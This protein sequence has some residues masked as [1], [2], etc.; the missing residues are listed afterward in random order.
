MG[1]RSAVLRFFELRP[2]RACFLKLAPW[3]EA[4]VR[5]YFALKRALTRGDLNLALASPLPS[6]ADLELE[7]LPEQ[8]RARLERWFAER[9]LREGTLER[10][11]TEVLAH[12]APAAKQ[13][14]YGWVEDRALEDE[15][16]IAYAE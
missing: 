9:L 8:E 5:S 10:T 3:F 11:L 1:L 13:R 2:I 15:H 6:A 7:A 16:A 12:A 14:F 4:R